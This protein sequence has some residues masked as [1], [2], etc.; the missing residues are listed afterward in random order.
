[1]E[2]TILE[3]LKTIRYPITQNI[4]LFVLNALQS[5][6]YNIEDMDLN[7]NV[8]RENSDLELEIQDD[9]DPV[10]TPPK[11]GEPGYYNPNIAD[12]WLLGYE[13]FLDSRDETLRYRD[14]T[15]SSTQSRE[16]KNFKAREQKDFKAQI[17]EPDELTLFA[18]ILRAIDNEFTPAEEKGEYF[19]SLD[20]KEIL[21]SKTNDGNNPYPV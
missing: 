10:Y 19:L 14:K 15:E 7:M 6:Y 16:Q 2:N 3:Y 13:Q 18:F 1:M 8:D 5:H 11:K 17:F 12:A 9:V 20:G 4:K 21:Y